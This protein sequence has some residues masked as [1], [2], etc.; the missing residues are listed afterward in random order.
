MS[1]VRAAR[2]RAR[3]LPAWAPWALGLA[4]PLGADLVLRALYDPAS[5][6]FQQRE[7]EVTGWLSLAA[8][9]LVLAS[10]PLRLVT[11]RR[12]LGLA[13]FGYALLH[14]VFS[15]TG[16]LG[17]DVQNLLFVSRSDQAGWALGL[18][19]LVGLLPLALTS[20]NAAMRRLGPRWK[21]LHA[22]G[23]WMTLLAALHTV[24][25]GVHFGLNPLAWT[26]VALLLL[27]ALALLGRRRKV[28]RIA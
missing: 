4:A 15:Y 1:S 11:Y 6:T 3:R 22:L 27:T 10:R 16:V 8:L 24:W 18:A 12:A 2:P 14:V 21:A 17:A 9:L 5:H 13:A 19:A 23:P 20:T 25:L 28:E 7:A 26:S